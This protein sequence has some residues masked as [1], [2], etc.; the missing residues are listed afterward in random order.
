MKRSLLIAILTL[1]NISVAAQAAAKSSSSANQR[2]AKVKTSQKNNVKKDFDSL[3]DNAA[4][5]ERAQSLDSKSQVQIVQ[6][7][8]V[9]RNN[10]LEIGLD[11]GYYMG[12]DSYYSTQS[13]GGSLNY[14]IN[15]R[16]S[17]GVRYAHVTNK[18]TSEGQSVFEDAQRRQDAHEIGFRIPDLD[19][20]IESGMAFINFYPIYG[21]LNFFD[22]AVS[23]FD[24]YLLAGY[25]KTRLNSGL[26]DT[27][28]GGLGLGIWFTQHL[29]ARLEGRYQT[30]NDRV[31]T[32]TRRVENVVAMAS[33][34]IML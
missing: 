11:Y 8:A 14:H 34:G 31:Y 30:Y 21:K 3:G 4:L 6:N 7:R 15:P 33:L 28:A 23:Q 16:W 27:F 2:K 32:G 9:D 13:L 12:G 26:S 17:L 20:P 25:G 22:A 24:V 10:R 1:A 29:A 18:L 19:Y 5:T